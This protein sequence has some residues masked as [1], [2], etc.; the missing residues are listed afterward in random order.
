[1][2]AESDSQAKENVQV[3][4][5]DAH[6]QGSN[7][8]YSILNI[9][10]EVAQKIANACMDLDVEIIRSGRVIYHEGNRLTVKL[11]RALSDVCNQAT[12]ID[13]FMSCVKAAFALSLILIRDKNNKP[14]CPFVFNLL[15]EEGTLDIFVGANGIIEKIVNTTARRLNLTEEA[16]K[17]KSDID[18]LINDIESYVNM[19]LGIVKSLALKPLMPDTFLKFVKSN[20]R[21]VRE[22]VL[23]LY[24]EVPSADNEGRIEP[25]ELR[26]RLSE[27][28]KALENGVKYD[29]GKKGVYVPG[30]TMPKILSPILDILMRQGWLPLGASFEFIE[31]IHEGYYEELMNTPIDRLRKILSR[32]ER[33]H[34][35]VIVLKKSENGGYVYNDTIDEPK[36]YVYYVPSDNELWVPP[37]LWADV[38]DDFDQIAVSREL[39]ENGLIKIEKTNRRIKTASGAVTV[40]VK[41]LDVNKFNQILSKDGTSFEDLA[42]I[43]R[44]GEEDEEESKKDDEVS[45]NARLT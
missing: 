35:T 17:L 37:S 26:V 38:V 15:N 24:L 25:V 20:V 28:S 22:G 8:G 29:V 43:L 27:V 36:N 45:N 12:N 31:K 41:V 30:K 10:A 3:N 9:Y 32:I 5:P 13:T 40:T 42:Y 2:S 34:W 16:E 33:K 21:D 44:G 19:Y 11:E 4:K 39:A 18:S 23:N 14:I 7:D 6:D 1:M